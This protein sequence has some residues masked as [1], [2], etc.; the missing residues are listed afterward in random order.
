MI[1]LFNYFFAYQGEIY[2]IIGNNGV[3]A[4]ANTRLNC[5]H[6]IVI[7]LLNPGKEKKECGA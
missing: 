6:K 4:K 5:I 1:H 2:C 3:R 7:F